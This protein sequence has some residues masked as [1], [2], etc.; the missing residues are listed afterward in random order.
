M[1][2][3]TLYLKWRPKQLDD[4]V[5]QPNLVQTLK[6][7]SISNKF[8]HAY[9]FSGNKGCGK[10]TSARIVANLMNCDDPKDGKVCGN[11]KACKTIPYGVA[12]DVVELDGA[13]QRKVEDINNLI[14]T[15]SWSPQELKKKVFIIDE[16]HQLSGTAIS[17][18][19][20]IVEEPP[21]YLTFIF[22][23]TELQK[24]PDT[25]LSRSQRH[26][27]HKISSKAIAGRL[28]YIA[29]EESINVDEGSLHA[30]AQLGRG[31]MRDAIGYLEQIATAAGNS[32]ISEEKVYKY[33]GVADRKGIYNIIQSMTTEN[34]SLLLDQ[35]NDMLV[36]SVDIRSILYEISEVFRNIL[37]IKA[38]GG[39]T[40]LVDLPDHEIKT[41]VKFGEM[42]NMGLGQL[43]RL[44]KDFSTIEK[45]LE[46]S[47]NKR[48]ILESTL[49]RCT[50]RLNL[51]K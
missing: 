25:I 41:L 36:A 40:R 35:V 51:K 5:G 10:T 21:E 20:K 11:C 50:A 14:D 30:I 46:Y 7:A 9:L 44:A 8:A 6:Q 37:V 38:Q 1:G 42:K 31:S 33:F 49:V 29:K 22:C 4:L 48:W 23:T 12:M 3:D 39:E 27:F 28:S 43:D 17:S 2:K 19:L 47:I 45:E 15:A 16:C 13:K 34:Y 18:L 26:V 32:A 24:I